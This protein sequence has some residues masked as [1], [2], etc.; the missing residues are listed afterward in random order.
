MSAEKLA[1]IIDKISKGTTT[2]VGQC[3]AATSR[4]IH[5]LAAGEPYDDITDETLS[6][7]AGEDTTVGGNGY[8]HLR[9]AVRHVARVHDIHWIRE[10]KGKRLICLDPR[11]RVDDADRRVHRARRAER[12]AVMEVRS[13][14]GLDPETQRRRDW[15]M[16]AA[17]SAQMIENERK[18]N[19]DPTPLLKAADLAKMI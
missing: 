9:S 7:I 14:Y 18:K 11:G 12:W 13:V 6:T 2:L 17:G 1:E 4:L 15:I 10:L 19:A 3:C 8:A 5:V 16:L